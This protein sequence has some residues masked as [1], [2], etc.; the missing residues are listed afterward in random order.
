MENGT[1]CD[2]A[3]ITF[4]GKAMGPAGGTALAPPHPAAKAETPAATI[5][6]AIFLGIMYVSMLT[7]FT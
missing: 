1:N 7:I 2:G 3:V 5:D 4:T 6:K